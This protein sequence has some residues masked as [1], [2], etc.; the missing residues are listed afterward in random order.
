M[1]RGLCLLQTPLHGV[2][3][4]QQSLFAKGLGSRGRREEACKR[5]TLQKM[6]AQGKVT[7]PSDA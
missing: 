7:C 6:E 5:R 1:S 4:R 2:E 3:G